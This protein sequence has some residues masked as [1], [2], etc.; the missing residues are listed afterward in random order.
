MSAKVVKN[1]QVDHPV[2][3]GCRAEFDA[4]S[5][6]LAGAGDG[7]WFVLFWNGTRCLVFD[8]NGVEARDLTAVNPK[9][10]PKC[11]ESGRCCFMLADQH[12]PFAGARELAVRDRSAA[13]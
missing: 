6:Q 2:E 8:P 7:E 4:R 10:L 13:G 5:Q 11:D 1:R 3:A 9:Q 12:R